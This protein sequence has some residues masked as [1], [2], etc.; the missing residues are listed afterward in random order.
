MITTNDTFKIVEGSK[1]AFAGASVYCI[2]TY[3][4]DIGNTYVVAN[5][6]EEISAVDTGILAT[7]TF[8]FLNDELYALSGSVTATGYADQYYNLV[9]LAVVSELSAISDNSGVTFNLS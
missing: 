3:Y 5:V 2:P 8:E 7:T 9:E 1:Q 6:V 4:E